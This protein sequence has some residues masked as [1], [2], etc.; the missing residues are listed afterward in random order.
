MKQKITMILTLV[1]LIMIAIPLTVSAEETEPVIPNEPGK[2]EN[3]GSITL[4]TD[5]RNSF[6]GFFYNNIMAYQIFNI[7]GNETTGWIY[8]IHDDFKTFEYNGL[9]DLDL[10]NYIYSL[11][12]EAAIHGDRVR[13]FT[14][15]VLMHILANEIMPTDEII[16]KQI[17]WYEWIINESNV[18][19]ITFDELPL[20]YY[21]ITGNVF[22]NRHISSWPLHA[23]SFMALANTD[24]LS[25]IH[26]SPKTDMPT[27]SARFVKE[28][29][30]NIA[31][32]FAVGDIMNAV[33]QTHIPL[34]TAAL[35]EFNENI[36]LNTWFINGGFALETEID[37]RFCSLVEDSIELRLGSN[38]G[39]IIEP[40][41]YTSDFYVIRNFESIII[42][43]G[44]RITFTNDFIRENEG[45]I[46][47]INMSFVKEN[48]IADP[49][50]SNIAVR[51]EYPKFEHQA[52]CSC[53]MC[54]EN[55]PGTR[56]SGLLTTTLHP[57]SYQKSIYKFTGDITGTHF[58]LGGDTGVTFAIS[59][60]PDL[61]TGNIINE[62]DL[63]IF[64]KIMHER[65]FWNQELQMSSWVEYEVYEIS[66]DQE[67]PLNNNRFKHLI[68]DEK[69]VISI[70]GLAFED[71]Y[72]LYETNTPA[73]YSQ[74]QAP[75][76]IDTTL[77]DTGTGFINVKTNPSVFINDGNIAGN[78]IAV[79]NN[80]SSM[81]PETGG[82]G[83]GIF[84]LIGSIIMTVTGIALIIKKKRNKK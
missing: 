29:P 20:G 33:I 3:T 13:K 31:P 55:E 40:E 22:I 73:G 23:A 52:R 17:P 70:I 44:V 74:L 37:V 19:S 26:V 79:Q 82:I 50:L 69:G 10:I 72:Y 41:N 14:Q 56:I 4:T 62:A 54:I 34:G 12:D 28:I 75:I 11:E 9:K 24:S 57:Q 36:E 60:E 84:L 38:T 18:T 39:P 76:Q 78:F 71:T 2:Q 65:W 45:E 30:S 59:T 15:A 16:T 27:L 32:F 83:T 49:S 77:V 7:S 42:R 5:Q 48:T 35:L 64:E 66:Q 46:I 81:F 58:A 43:K 1:I 21:L 25:S 80:R 53:P 6:V 47:I 51:L 63:I 67:S 61:Q 8:T 68:P